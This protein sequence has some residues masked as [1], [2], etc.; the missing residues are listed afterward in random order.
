MVQCIHITF[1]IGKL[2][3]L[4]DEYKNQL[5]TQAMR[6]RNTGINSI[7]LTIRMNYGNTIDYKHI[8]IVEAIQHINDCIYH[9]LKNSIAETSYGISPVEIVNIEPLKFSRGSM[10]SPTSMDRFVNSEITQR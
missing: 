4:G 9:H 5:I 3:A 1:E 6:L 10:H 2:I 7:W 8:T